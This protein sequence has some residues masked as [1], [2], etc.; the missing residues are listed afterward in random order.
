MKP[1]STKRDAFGGFVW[2]LVGLYDGS[3]GSQ[4]PERDTRIQEDA[5]YSRGCLLFKRMP[6]S[7]WMG[8]VIPMM[9]LAL[10]LASSMAAWMVVKS[11]PKAHTGLLAGAAAGVGGMG[12][13]VGGTGVAPLAAIR[14]YLRL[15]LSRDLH[16]RG[17]FR[18]QIQIGVF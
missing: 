1:S 11:Q 10:V 6:A 17:H 14:R 5:S 4:S 18:P 12:V 15:N 13:V 2:F 9:A 7:V 8:S 3:I 16:P